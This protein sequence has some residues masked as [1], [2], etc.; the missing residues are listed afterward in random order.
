MGEE[1]YYID[2]ISEY[3]SENILKPEDRDFDQN[4]VFGADV[5]A[6]Q[7]VDL[8]KGFPWM[9][10]KK[11]VI[12]KEA[13]ALRS[14]EAFD[15]YAENPS[16]STVLVICYKNG[17]IDR[18]KKFMQRAQSVGIV[19]ESK[20]KRESELPAFIERYLSQHKATIEQKAAVMIADHIGADLN[21]LVSE[22]DKLLITVDRNSE[23]AGGRDRRVTPE[24]V[25]TQIG[26]SKEFNGFELRNAIVQ[27][28]VFK[29]NQIINYFD[30]NPKSGSIYMLLPTLF[31]YFSNLMLAYYSPSKD[32]NS[33]AAFLGLRGG[34]AAR[35]YIVGM[36]NYPG[37]KTMQIIAKIREVDAKS[38]G[39]D[40]P[41][42]SAADLMKELVFFILH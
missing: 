16:L 24:M 12:V 15:K 32:E 4:V 28:N 3:I 29:A 13:Q 30:K 26:V 8:A 35:D 42:T 36:R 19:F 40:N 11:V 10:E 33:V 14:M 23:N 38:K 9:G 18:R 39:L 34:W 41:S 27:R 21:R 17:T 31:S 5:T 6:A 7:V 2:K 37:V 1:S 20:K 22:L 25:E